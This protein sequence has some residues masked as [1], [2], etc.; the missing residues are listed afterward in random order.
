MN[1]GNMYYNNC[2]DNVTAQTGMNAI[3]YNNAVSNTWSDRQC[4][5][6]A[7]TDA[8]CVCFRLDHKRGKRVHTK[9][10][11]VKILYPQV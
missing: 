4:G 11:D 2:T 10:N 6:Q 3:L 9:E 1:A 8:I 7:E 5:T